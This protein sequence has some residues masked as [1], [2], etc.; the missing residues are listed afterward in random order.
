MSRDTAPAR[1]FYSAMIT[2]EITF[3]AADSEEAEDVVRDR[4][5]WE[6][7]TLIDAT[8]LSEIGDDG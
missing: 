4:L 3:Y 5:M 7:F 6:S 8:G 1:R 2:A